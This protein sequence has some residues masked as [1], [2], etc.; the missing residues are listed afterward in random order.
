MAA[1]R[2]P[3]HDDNLSDDLRLRILTSLMTITFHQGQPP[4][5]TLIADTVVTIPITANDPDYTEFHA[6]DINDHL[7]ALRTLQ[8]R[9]ML[10]S[11]IYLQLDAYTI[12][13]NTVIVR[14]FRWFEYITNG[15]ARDEISVQLPTPLVYTSDPAASLTFWH[16]YVSRV[17]EFTDNWV[18]DFAFHAWYHTPPL[19]GIMHATWM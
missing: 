6:Q 19:G 11:R 1:P 5:Y 2:P 7:P 8:D 9:W 15:F 18:I 12:N 13:N 17:E 4:A 3:Q 14:D 10:P 16:A